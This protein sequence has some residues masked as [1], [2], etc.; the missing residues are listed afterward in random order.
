MCSYTLSFIV[1]YILRAV[2]MFLYPQIHS[3]R[4]INIC[5]NELKWAFH[6]HWS[7]IAPKCF[8]VCI[9]LPTH[10]WNFIS[11]AKALQHLCGFTSFVFFLNLIS[12]PDGESEHQQSQ[13]SLFWS[14]LARSFPFVG[15]WVNYSA[16]QIPSCLPSHSASATKTPRPCEEWRLR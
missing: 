14:W 12:F 1:G 5:K 3:Q 7:V 4:S 10:S 11:A 16:R 13:T 6:C 8:M 15:L 9:L 2:S